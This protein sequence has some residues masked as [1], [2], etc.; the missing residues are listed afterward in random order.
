M[1][2]FAKDW[3]GVFGQTFGGLMPLHLQ[4]IASHCQCGKLANSKWQS[5]DIVGNAV[6]T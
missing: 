6:E 3:M 1:R 5:W 4:A 2:T